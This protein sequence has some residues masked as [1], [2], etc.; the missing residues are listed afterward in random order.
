LRHIS[1]DATLVLKRF[2]RKWFL[3]CVLDSSVSGKGQAEGCYEQ[4]NKPL[5]SIKFGNFLDQLSDFHI[6]KKNLLC[7][8]CLA[9]CKGK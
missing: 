6:L 8:K 7:S 3:K 9:K 4:A 5:G 2:I 1:L